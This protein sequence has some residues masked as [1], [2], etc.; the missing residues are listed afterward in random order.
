[1]KRV[2]LPRWFGWAEA[3]AEFLA[4]WMARELTYRRVV[5]F[6]G[7][8]LLRPDASLHYPRPPPAHCAA[9]ADDTTMRRGNS[10][11]D[12]LRRRCENTLHLTCNW[13][14]GQNSKTTVR[15]LL[16]L[17]GPLKLY[18][19]MQN[20]NNRSPAASLAYCLGVARGDCVH[21]LTD[22]RINFQTAG[23]RQKLGFNIF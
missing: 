7:Y 17:C 5:I 16:A 9:A 20:K 10:A 15:A 12:A 18:H 2:G 8:A 11:D 13:V 23:G 4:V 21:C 3:A 6:S 22:T 14:P 19:G 1:M